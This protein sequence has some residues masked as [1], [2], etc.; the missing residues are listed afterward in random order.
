[1]RTLQS[2]EFIPNARTPGDHGDRFGGP[3]TLLGSHSLLDGPGQRPAHARLRIDRPAAATACSDCVGRRRHL[4]S[5]AR[6]VELQ[7]RGVRCSGVLRWRASSMW[8]R[9]G[10]AESTWS[11]GCRPGE[12]SREQEQ[13]GCRAALD[14][15]FSPLGGKGKHAR[16]EAGGSHVWGTDLRIHT[17]PSCNKLDVHP[18]PASSLPQPAPSSPPACIARHSSPAAHSS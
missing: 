17:K 7:C 6:V 4:P 11:R 9:R 3:L 10:Q 15:W 5:Q 8:R 2:G 18:L 13:G 16:P 1:M 12:W 14:I